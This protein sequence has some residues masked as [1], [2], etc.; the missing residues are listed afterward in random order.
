MTNGQAHQVQEELKS[1]VLIKGEKENS[2][3]ISNLDVWI[4]RQ[5]Q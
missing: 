5:M 3:K 4:R 1:F 2:L